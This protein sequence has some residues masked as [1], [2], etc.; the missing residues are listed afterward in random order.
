MDSSNEAEAFNDPTDIFKWF[1]REG[2]RERQAD[3]EIG[4]NAGRWMPGLHGSGRL[5]TL[6]A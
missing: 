1:M 6:M 5:E 3:R 4:L 2:E